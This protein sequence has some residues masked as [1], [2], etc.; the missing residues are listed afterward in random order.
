M[1]LSDQILNFVTA[2]ELRRHGAELTIA[3]THQAVEAAWQDIRSGAAMGGKAVLSLPEAEFWSQPDFIGYRESF[4][5]ERLG[6]KLSSLYSVNPR[7]GGVKIIGANAFN[8]RRGLPRSTSTYLLLEKTTLRPIAIFDG[9]G[10]SAAR[11]GTYASLILDTFVETPM[12]ISVFLFGTGPVARSVID[13]LSLTGAERIERIFIRSRLPENAI[14]F[15]DATAP[16]TPITLI[17]AEDNASLAECAFVITATNAREP[18]FEDHELARDVATL[19]LG[20]DEVPG[21][22]LKRALRT[23]TVICDD[24]KTVSR[25]NSQSVSL[26][27]SRKGLSLETT[28]PLLGI[29][30]LSAPTGW[31]DSRPGPVCVTCVGLPML[32][33]YAAEAT[34]TKLL[35]ARGQ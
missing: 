4:A 6:W 26:Y 17:P 35:K 33:L 9:T 25:R 23:G 28:G 1:V 27:F 7:F 5:S 24:L 21:A 30:E 19:H 2:E 18:V 32:D 13:C 31:Q 10:L 34:W 15:V 22:Y 11:T 16:S 12:K 29:G 20:G 8:R 14:R 3:E